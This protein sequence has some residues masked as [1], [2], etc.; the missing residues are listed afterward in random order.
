MLQHLCEHI[1]NINACVTGPVNDVPCA[2][3]RHRS[4]LVFAVSCGYYRCTN[5]E[6]EY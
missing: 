5:L 2:Q 4:V 3:K 6:A 1:C